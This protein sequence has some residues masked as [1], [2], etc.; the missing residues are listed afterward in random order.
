MA[1]VPPGCCGDTNTARHQRERLHLG[2]H[3]A[4]GRRAGGGGQGAAGADKSPMAA[5]GAPGPGG[6]AEELG[7]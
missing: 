4:G 1:P 6:E 2:L 7:R 3:R 5:G